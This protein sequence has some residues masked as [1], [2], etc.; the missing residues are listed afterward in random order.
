[1]H[2]YDISSLTF[3]RLRLRNGK[4]LD[5]QIPHNNKGQSVLVNPELAATLYT[6]RF[7]YVQ[8]EMK[9][10]IKQNPQANAQRK[11]VQRKRYRAVWPLE[12]EKDPTF[13]E[14]FEKKSRD[15]DRRQ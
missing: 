4:P 7:F 10:W 2:A 3:K 15:H 6:P 8:Y 9:Q 12:K 13:G 1:L 11:S 14:V 5:K